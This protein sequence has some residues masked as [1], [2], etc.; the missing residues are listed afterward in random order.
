MVQ[1]RSYVGP[2]A[3]DAGQAVRPKPAQY[4]PVE[5]PRPGR[6]R[7]ARVHQAILDTTLELLGEMGYSRLTIEGVAARAGVGKGTIYR[8][9]PSKGALV[10]ETIAAPVC[11]IA[12]GRWTVRLGPLP[13]GGGLRADLICF[14]QRVNYAFNAPLAAETLP[15]LATDLQQDAELLEMFRSFIVQPKRERLAEVIE[16]AKKRGE[17]DAD[18]EVDVGLLCDMLVGPLLYRS[19]LTG[20]PTDDEAT[21]MLVDQV[22]RSLPVHV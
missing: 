22:M 16:L 7:D 5:R 10:V 12:T 21:E 18:A 13:D 17:V 9:W 14:V 4:E 19:M 8:H 2:V 20:Q 1:S 15:G 6:P 3:L 11:P